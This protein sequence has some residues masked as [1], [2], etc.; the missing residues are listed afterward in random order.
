MLSKKM[1]LFNFIL[2]LIIQAHLKMTGR[3]LLDKQTRDLI[4]NWPRP[5]KIRN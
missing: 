3:H 1:S 2:K 5:A 4:H